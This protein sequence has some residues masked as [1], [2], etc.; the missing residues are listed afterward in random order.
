MRSENMKYR[1]KSV[2]MTGVIGCMGISMLAGCS[3]ADKDMAKAADPDQLVG[4]FV[5]AET[6]PIYGEIPCNIDLDNGTISIEG[7]ENAE[8]CFLIGAKQGE[9]NVTT[10]SSCGIS[11]LENNVNVDDS[12]STQVRNETI[13]GCMYIDADEIERYADAD[14]EITFTM[15]NIYETADEKYYVSIGSSV[16]HELLDD[17]ESMYT[18]SLGTSA[19]TEQSGINKFKQTNTVNVEWKAA[20]SADSYT[21][22]AMSADDKK[23]DEKSYDIKTLPETIKFDCDWQYVVISYTDKNGSSHYSLVDRENS[24][25][26]YTM[27][28]GK[29]YLDTGVVDVE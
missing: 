27:S 1:L 18:G 10:I 19:G 28:T 20:T 8:G 3:L 13:S 15:Y 2:I 17:D 11:D 9:D 7:L 22:T 29:F 16:T 26:E 24:E 23:L 5:S 14:G 25:Y 21:F 4:A 12:S 6:L